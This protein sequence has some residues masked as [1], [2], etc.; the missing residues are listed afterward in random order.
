[1]TLVSSDGN[2]FRHTF[3]WIEIKSSVEDSFRRVRNLVNFF[4]LTIV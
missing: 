2:K 4:H 1:M 3:I